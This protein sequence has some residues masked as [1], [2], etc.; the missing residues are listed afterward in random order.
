MITVTRFIIDNNTYFEVLVPELPDKDNYFCEP[1]EKLHVFD[2]VSVVYCNN[3]IKTE[4]LQDDAAYII[5]VPHSILTKALK[6]KRILPDHIPLGSTSLWFSIDSAK[7]DHDVEFGSFWLWSSP[8]KVQIWLYNKDSKIYLEISS[9]YP[10][11]FV[12]P[13]PS[14]NYYSLDEYIKNYKPIAVYE[15][16]RETAQQWLEQCNTILDAM[17]APPGYT[18]W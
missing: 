2:I 7:D 12:D 18:R 10:W 4:L 6:N 3:N 13:K 16:S 11:L 1:T 9:T 5:G 14:D 8:S 17:D 15:I